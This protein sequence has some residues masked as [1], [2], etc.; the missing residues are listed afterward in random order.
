MQDFIEH[1]S[2]RNFK[3]IKELELENCK[4]INLFIGNPNTGKS[5]ILEALSLLSMP[6]IYYDKRYTKP[7]DFVRINDESD[8]FFNGDTTNDIRVDVNRKNTLKLAYA[9]KLSKLSISPD[10]FAR[11]FY[12]FG[13]STLKPNKDA[14]DILPNNR[15]K[16]YLFPSTY[17]FDNAAC[18]FLLP[19]YGVNL[20]QILE[21]SPKLMKE[22]AEELGEGPTPFIDKM[23]MKLKFSKDI[24]KGLTYVQTFGAISEGIRRFIFYRAAIESNSN[25]TIILDT[26]ESLLSATQILIV[27]QDIIASKT[28]QFFICSHYPFLIVNILTEA[29]PDVAVFAVNADKEQTTARRLN[30]AE[31]ADI[32]SYGS[33]LFYEVESL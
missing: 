1:I 19:P 25:S 30:D 32:L 26:P 4:R 28:N 13:K 31:L 21:K 22:L 29:M 6:H 16:T 20:V 2:I 8:L 14:M 33:D 5:N 11:C 27:S 12:S 24:G 17:R 15:Y 23:S 10:G 3:S 7:T 18:R 9:E